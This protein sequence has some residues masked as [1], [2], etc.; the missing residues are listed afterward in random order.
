MD[1]FHGQIILVWELNC[2]RFSYHL[3]IKEIGNCK[4][5]SFGLT[6]GQ[7]QKSLSYIETL[8]DAEKTKVK[9]MG[10]IQEKIFLIVQ[11][12]KSQ[13]LNRKTVSH[14]KSGGI[15]GAQ[16]EDKKEAR[17]ELRTKVGHGKASW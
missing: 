10:G 9:H 3:R 5:R 17:Q 11:L 7:R 2:G 8:K 1:F 13:W 4:A 12:G 16:I 15:A 14:G 6:E